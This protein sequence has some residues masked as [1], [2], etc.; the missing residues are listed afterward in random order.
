M[1]L[2][3]RY[4][5]LAL[6]LLTALVAGGV[7]FWYGPHHV[8]E[9]PS[10]HLEDEFTFTRD[11]RGDKIV[12]GPRVLRYYLP[13]ESLDRVQLHYYLQGV[14]TDHEKELV[15]IDELDQWHKTVLG[16]KL[17]P[18]PPA[19]ETLFQE[20]IDREV[21]RIEALGFRAGMTHY[22]EMETLDPTRMPSFKSNDPK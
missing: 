8:V 18:L 6:F 20:A 17:S 2:R 3:P 4:S 10:P 1:F 22:L 13:E 14:K 15:V 12:H 7:K 5:L 16:S 19:D 21:A 9:R 11:W